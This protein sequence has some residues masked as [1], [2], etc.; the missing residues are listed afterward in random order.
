MPQVG[1]AI[2]GLVATVKTSA[3]FTFLTTTFVGKL[4]TSVALSALL[5]AL[6]PKPKPNQGGIVSETTSTG[7][8]IGQGAVL[9]YYATAGH[10][11]CPPMTHGNVGRVQNAYLTY[12]VAVS[13]VPG[14]SLQSLIVN[15]EVVSLGG[16]AE[17][18]GFPA[19]GTFAGHLWVRFYDGSQTTADSYL[20]SRYGSASDHA[21]RTGRPWLSDM[22]GRGM[23]YA[24]VTFRYNRQ[25]YNA[26][27]SVR[28]VLNGIPL[29]DPRQ[30]TTVGGSGSQRWADRST[31][32]FT[33][34]PKVMIYNIMRGIEIPES[35]VWGPQVAAEDLPLSSWFA[36]MNACDE[37]VGGVPQY[38]AG[39]EFSVLQEPAEV[40][41]ELEKVCSGAMSE[42]GGVWKARAGAPGMP[43]YYFSDD[44]L[45]MDEGTT[46]VPFGSLNETYN[47]ITA[48]YPDPAQLWQAKEAP[49]RFNSILEAEDFGRRLV[50]SLNLSA[51]P[52]A[53]QVQ[54][55]MQAYI[56]DERRFRR[57]SLVLPPDA[58]LAVVADQLVAQTDGVA[59]TCEEAC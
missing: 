47:G 49:P 19:L 27:P 39:Y 41:E 18:E 25:L 37:S 31:W 6:Q 21:A 3:V 4:L 24:V 10:H 44:D 36:A 48:R 28:F 23:C 53:E 9:G 52:Y 59:L 38:R 54:R 8:E 5:R 16:V 51:C 57:H 42:F 11:L 40:I 12:V 1:V 29:Y 34:N 7:E 17:T 45:I 33:T 14:A 50:A 13:D 58:S 26:L 56:S 43:V 20:L 2:A 35:G 22:V 55:L 30:D 15:D 32:T 46:F